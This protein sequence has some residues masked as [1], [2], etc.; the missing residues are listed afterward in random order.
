MVAQGDRISL[1][2]VETEPANNSEGQFISAGT[3]LVCN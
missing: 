2:F 1:Q 3:T